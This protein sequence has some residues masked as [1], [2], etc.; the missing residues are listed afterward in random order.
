[1]PWAAIAAIASLAATGVGLGETLANRPSTPKITTTPA[2][3]TPQQG[4]QIKAAISGQ[5][6]NIQAQTGGSLSP[7]YLTQIAPVLAGVAGPGTSGIA[8]GATNTYTGNANPIAQVLRVLAG[9]GG[10]GTSFS[11]AGI[12]PSSGGSIVDSGLSDLY[13]NLGF[14]G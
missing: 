2:P 10:G 14:K 12:A 8:Q 5:D 4:N 11:P 1:M 6:A 9:G 13:Q 7:D 3:L